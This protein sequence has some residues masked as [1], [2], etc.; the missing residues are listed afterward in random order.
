VGAPLRAH[1]TL[2]A[3]MPPGARST[4]VRVRP[5]W[6]PAGIVAGVLKVPEATRRASVQVTQG[7]CADRV[8]I[9]GEPTPLL[10]LSTTPYHTC[11]VASRRNP[12]GADVIDC[13]HYCPET[14]R[15]VDISIIQ[16]KMNQL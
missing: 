16:L 3:I 9:P 11:R 8:W 15:S 6:E 1:A 14:S 12:P 5:A 7:L 13:F 4:G 10:A 2:S